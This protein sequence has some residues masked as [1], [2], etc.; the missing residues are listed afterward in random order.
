MVAFSDATITGLSSSSWRPSRRRSAS[1]A[2]ASTSAPVARA[3]AAYPPP[4]GGWVAGLLAATRVARDRGSNA[5]RLLALGG[6]P[7]TM[8][9]HIGAERRSGDAETIEKRVRIGLDL[10]WLEALFDW[11]GRLEPV[12]GHEQHD[13]VR[14]RDLTSMD[15]LA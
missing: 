7:R 12:T 5:D 3:A 13:V 4:G 11:I 10:V 8:S 6:R 1:A 14:L 2:R 9:C 15:G